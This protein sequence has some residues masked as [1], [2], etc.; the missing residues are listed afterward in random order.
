MATHCTI[1]AWEIPRTEE[2][3]GLQCMGSQV[4]G[5]TERTQHSGSNSAHDRNYLWEGMV[6]HSQKR[7]P[8]H[9]FFTLSLY[10]P[11]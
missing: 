8:P 7:Q 6:R 1:L 5:T 2:P 3:G 11:R 10:C 9:V 4:S